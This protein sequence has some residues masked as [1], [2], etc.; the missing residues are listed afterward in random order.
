MFTDI[1]TINLIKKKLKQFTCHL[2]EPLSMH[3]AGMWK[4]TVLHTNKNLSLSHA[5][6]LHHLVKFEYRYKY[7]YRYK[8]TKKIQIVELCYTSSIHI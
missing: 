8:R 3:W 6:S 2:V 1:N 5:H 4:D 7:K